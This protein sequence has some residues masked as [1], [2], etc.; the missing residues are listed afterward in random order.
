[1]LHKTKGIVLKTVKYG[2]T[3]LIA[4]LYT[5]LFGLQT[6]IVSGVRTSSKKGPGKANLFQPS[7]ILDLIVYHND[8]KNL[9]RIRE[10][11][12]SA[13]YQ[14]IFFDVLK[15]AV[16]VFMVE[17]LTKCIKQPEPNP[18]LFYFIEDAFLHL[19]T[20]EGRVQA[21][22]PLFF[23]LHLAGFFG[24]R[25][26]DI[27][28][29]KTPFL[30]LQEGQFVAEHPEHH[31]V[32]E[33]NHSYITAQLLRAQQPAE[34]QE[35]ALNQETRRALL[36]AYQLFYALHIPEFGEMRTLSVL[37]TVLA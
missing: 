1:M 9:Q 26:Q 7:A 4:T 23:M 11:K 27:Y 30:D 19:D 31:Q 36:Q 18:D 16:A 20:S 10:M 35:L 25:I 14:H 12:W 28:S 29:E 2:E 3:S 17:L 34:L 5:E 13:L 15:N 33:G 37:Q 24:F 32:L 6:Y 8:L 22:F 21:N